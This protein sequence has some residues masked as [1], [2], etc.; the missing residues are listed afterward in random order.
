[1]TT[2]EHVTENLKVAQEAHENSLATEDIAIINKVKKIFNERIKINCTACS[3]CMP[4]PVGINIPGCFATYNDYWSFDGSLVAKQ[5]YAIMSKLGT[6]ASKCVEC[7]KCESHC[8]QSI[9]IR[10]ELKNVKELFE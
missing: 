9:E 1:M 3:Y 5:R 4:C 10:K 8:P 7:G 6:P 2:M